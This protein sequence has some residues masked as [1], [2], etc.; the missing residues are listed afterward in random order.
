MPELPSRPLI[1]A[2]VALGA[3]AVPAV[4]LAVIPPNDDYLKS[5]L[6]EREYEVTSKVRRGG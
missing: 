5:V 2:L 4:A 1:A 6:T 3:L